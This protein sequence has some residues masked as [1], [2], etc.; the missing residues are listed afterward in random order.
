MKQNKVFYL[1]GILQNHQ[2]KIQNK[3]GAVSN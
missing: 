1:V 2:K 3:G